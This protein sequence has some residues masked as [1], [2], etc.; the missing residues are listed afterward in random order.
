[1]SVV[2]ENLHDVLSVLTWV[3]CSSF[4]PSLAPCNGGLQEPEASR[5]DRKHARALASEDVRIKEFFLLSLQISC[6]YLNY[7]SNLHPTEEQ[8]W[9]SLT[10][11]RGLI[12]SCCLQLQQRWSERLYRL[13]GVGLPCWMLLY[14]FSVQC[15]LHLPTVWNLLWLSTSYKRKWNKSCSSHR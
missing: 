9:S 1:M 13:S 2:T 15:H 8:T 4:V 6:F 7:W 5:E 14:A 10:T 12:D 3:R 11:E